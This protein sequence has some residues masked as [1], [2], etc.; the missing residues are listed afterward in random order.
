MKPGGLLEEGK[1][2]LPTSYRGFGAVADW[3]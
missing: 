1:R 3:V 2:A